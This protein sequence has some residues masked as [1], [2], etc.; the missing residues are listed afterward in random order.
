VTVALSGDGGDE[1]FGG[2]ETYVANQVAKDYS[3]LPAFARHGIVEP[4]IGRLRP[5]EEKKG[6]VNKAKRFVEGAALP[7]SL[8]HARWRAFMNDSERSALF[9][10]DLKTSID[11]NPWQH[12]VDLHARAERFDAVDRALYVDTKSYLVDNC[13][14]KTDRMSMA[15]SLEVRVPLLGKEVVELAFSLPSRLKVARRKTKILLKRVA[16]RHVPHHCVYR[17]KQGFSIPIKNWLGTQFREV[18]ENY[19]EAGRLRRAGLFDATTVERLKSEH[20]AGHA[21]HSHVLWSLIVFERWRSTWLEGSH[22]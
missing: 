3:R 8:G 21:N 20:L 16:A 11:R 1:L 15:V 19:L 18:M 10:H 13:L 22:G 5:R 12:I 7:A 2:Y 9:S 17:G 4:L 14:V 6:L